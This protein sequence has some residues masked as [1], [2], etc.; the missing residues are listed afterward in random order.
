MRP[1]SESPTHVKEIV[2]SVLEWVPEHAEEMVYWP[3]AEEKKMDDSSDMTALKGSDDEESSV[4]NTENGYVS[5]DW[6][7][8]LAGK[9]GATLAAIAA[10]RLANAL[11]VEVSLVVRQ[12]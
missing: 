12:K 10:K 8:N 1:R 2:R 7:A 5:E 9:N 11:N 3:C 4:G 6:P